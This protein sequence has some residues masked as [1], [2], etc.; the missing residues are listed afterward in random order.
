MIF[1]TC[2]AENYPSFQLNFKIFVKF[3]DYALTNPLARYPIGTPPPRTPS[4]GRRPEE[5]EVLATARELVAGPQTPLNTEKSIDSQRPY[6][7]TTP[8]TLSP[9][10]PATLGSKPSTPESSEF[11]ERFEIQRSPAERPIR[12]I[13]VR[14]ANTQ[15][16]LSSEAQMRTNDTTQR[17]RRRR[18]PVPAVEAHYGD[19]LIEGPRVV[20]GDSSAFWTS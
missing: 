15:R 16:A 10:S 8:T 14:P 5:K 2:D 4:W 13:D 12:R 18:A 17:R 11:S 20:E 3:S 1:C 6:G 9:F 7:P 19:P